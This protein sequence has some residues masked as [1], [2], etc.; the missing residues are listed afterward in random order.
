MPA[1]IRV[2]LSGISGPIQLKC[3]FFLG[4]FCGLAKMHLVFVHA[5]FRVSACA[6]T[7]E[8]EVCF[9]DITGPLRGSAVCPLRFPPLM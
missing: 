8:L 1:A 7:G 5:A 2:R 9:A 4:Q 6:N 3:S